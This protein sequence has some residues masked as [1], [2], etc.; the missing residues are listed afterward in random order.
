MADV[1]RHTPMYLLTFN[2][3]RFRFEPNYT[4]KLLFLF[5]GEL[6]VFSLNYL[7]T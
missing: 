4:L 7:T 6:G 3:F 5:F 2:T 1:S